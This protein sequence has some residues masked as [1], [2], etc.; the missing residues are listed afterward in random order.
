MCVDVADAG[1][2]EAAILDQAKYFLVGG[3]HGRGKPLEQSQE[4]LPLR[5][6]SEGKF[7]DDVGMG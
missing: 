6:I 7:A 4:G 3:H 1:S 2:G 5:K